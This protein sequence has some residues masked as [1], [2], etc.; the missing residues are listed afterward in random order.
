MNDIVTKR[1]F[2]LKTQNY[3]RFLVYVHS[4]ESNSSGE[5]TSLQTKQDK[6]SSN[7]KIN[8]KWWSNVRFRDNYLIVSAS[9]TIMASY[10]ARHDDCRTF[11]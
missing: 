3:V 2:D 9:H 6:L 11:L 1:T 5:M 7:L 10:P 8:F 4:K